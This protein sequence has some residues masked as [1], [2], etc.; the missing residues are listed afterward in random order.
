MGPP[1]HFLFP[2]L[3]AC[4][5]ALGAGLVA[6]NLGARPLRLEIGAFAGGYAAGDWSRSRRLD[7]DPQATTD[8][9][10]SFY[11]RTC[12]AGSRFEFPV[13]LEDG[14]LRF[15]LRGNTTVRGAVGGFLGAERVGEM[16]VRP[17]PWGAHSL[18]VQSGALR[19]GPLEM[20]LALRPLPQVRGDHV[21]DPELHVD[22]VEVEAPRGL[23]LVPGAWLLVAAMVFLVFVS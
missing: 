8:G 12:L 4:L 1:R 13:R 18:E 3:V 11:Y 9:R 17:G 7:V 19:S 22:Y 14:P 2:S 20:S 5:L 21:D 6:R 23:T 15:T 10:T 16:V